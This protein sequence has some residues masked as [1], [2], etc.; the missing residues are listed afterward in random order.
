MDS[1]R[2]RIGTTAA[3][4]LAALALALT[5]S[6]GDGNGNDGGAGR[7]GAPTVPEPP[8]RTAAPPPAT[9]PAAPAETRTTAPAEARTTAPA[10]VRTDP[11]ACFDGSCEITVTKPMAIRVDA[12]RFGFSSVRITRIGAGG[13]TVEADSGGTYLQSGVSA[14]GTAALNDLAVR[15]R[16]VHGGTARLELS[17]RG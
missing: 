7:H 9:R 12:D 2:L 3:A 1:R 8:A 11:A 15:V 6:C 5:A 13:V 10:E 4:V 14:G 17:A 16:S